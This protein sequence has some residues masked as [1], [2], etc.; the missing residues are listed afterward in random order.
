MAAKEQVQT[1][2]VESVHV[3]Y[4]RHYPG[5]HHVHVLPRLLLQQTPESGVIFSLYHIQRLN[6]LYIHSF[7]L[8]FLAVT[9]RLTIII[10]QV[11]PGKGVT[12]GDYH[13]CVVTTYDP[14]G[15]GN[16]RI[17]EL[18]LSDGSLLL[19]LVIGNRNVLSSSSLKR[20][21]LMLMNRNVIS[22]IR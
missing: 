20:I 11:V 13:R 17:R 9:S 6:T 18:L 2:R 10:I 19:L 3:R 12:I 16:T 4:R 1:P 21:E 8:T 5:L 7:L 15:A 14:R 22:N